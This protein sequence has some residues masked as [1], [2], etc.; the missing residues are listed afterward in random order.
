MHI[1]PRRFKEAREFRRKAQAN[2]A[3][4]AR[5]LFRREAEWMAKQPKA[6]Q[7]KSMARQ[8][9]GG[10]GLKGGGVGAGAGGENGGQQAAVDKVVRMGWGRKQGVG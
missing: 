10:G 2:A 3:A 6:R 5:T 9:V 4:D 8:Q 7:A 1:P